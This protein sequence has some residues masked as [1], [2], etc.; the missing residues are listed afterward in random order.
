M[1]SVGT[2]QGSAVAGCC[3][4]TKVG[5]GFLNHVNGMLASISSQIEENRRRIYHILL[6]NWECSSKKV[7]QIV[8]FVSAAAAQAVLKDQITHHRSRRQRGSTGHRHTQS[9]QGWLLF[10][11]LAASGPFSPIIRSGWFHQS[12]CPQRSPGDFLK[13]YN[14]TVSRQTLQVFLSRSN[15][16]F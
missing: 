12:F 4:P 10:S 6:K 5:P 16:T 3:P 13:L 2:S 7:R 9:K 8:T 1:Q 14:S 11:A 15:M